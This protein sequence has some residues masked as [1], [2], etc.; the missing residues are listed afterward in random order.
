MQVE[1]FHDLLIAEPPLCTLTPHH[2]HH[3]HHHQTCQHGISCSWISP[4]VLKLRYWS[5][6]WLSN[7]ADEE[8]GRPIWQV[9][10]LSFSLNHCRFSPAFLFLI[11]IFFLDDFEQV[12]VW[13]LGM[14][15]SAP[16]TSHL[17]SSSFYHLQRAN[18][19][20]VMIDWFLVL[21]GGRGVYCSC[22][23]HVPWWP[24]YYSAIL[25]SRQMFS[26]LAKRPHSR[27]LLPV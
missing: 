1:L 15:E 10:G 25:K 27:A 22:M 23:C 19:A 24:A 12:K 5:A 8:Y 20:A 18:S 2:N 3:H 6:K 17:R 4:Q 11:V 7:S 16:P 13:P 26:S 21:K 9:A 14:I